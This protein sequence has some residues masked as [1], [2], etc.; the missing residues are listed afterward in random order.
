MSKTPL[1]SKFWIP[2]S[3]RGGQA[4]VEAIVALGV[5]LMGMMGALTLLSQSLSLN[6]V[7]SNSYTATYL[8]AEG[9]E[10]VKNLIDHNNILRATSEPARAWDAGIAEGV[11]EVEWDDSELDPNRPYR[12]L[13]L[14]F[15]P[16]D[17]L[18]SYNSIGTTQT[19]FK[20][21]VTITKGTDEIGVKSK[22]DWTTRGGGDFS[23]TMEGH[24]FKWR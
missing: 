20:R 7:V 6:R 3:T 5:L 17:A 8:A 24:F 23:I 2:N 19:A 10:I 15:H 18:Y 11:Y 22:V 1:K 9:V 12:D 13:F 14:R 21:T 4:L 16:V